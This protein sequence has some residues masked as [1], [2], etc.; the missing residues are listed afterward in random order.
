MCNAKQA[1]KKISNSVPILGA[2]LMLRYHVQVI[3]V[4]SGDLRMR[5][6]TLVNSGGFAHAR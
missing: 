5:N 3:L 6:S 1:L 4:F 2:H